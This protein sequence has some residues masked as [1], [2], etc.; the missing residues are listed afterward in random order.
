MRCTQRNASNAPPVPTSRPFPSRLA[1]HTNKNK[2]KQT[3]GYFN[4]DTPPVARLPDPIDFRSLV[5]QSEYRLLLSRLHREL[6][7]DWLTPAE[8]FRPWLG[9]ALA[10]YC[11][12]ERRHLWGASEPLVIV[13]VGGGTGTLAAD[14]L[15]R[16]GYQSGCRG[17]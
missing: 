8:I 9:R 12:E 4:R 14:V 17:C 15:V 5:G 3:L 1:T 7:A 16:G 10:K 6:G 11:L 2:T 13:E